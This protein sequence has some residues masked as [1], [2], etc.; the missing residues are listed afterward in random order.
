MYIYI[1]LFMFIPSYFFVHV[2][3]ARFGDRLVNPEVPA[4]GESGTSRERGF[5]DGA[6]ESA[7]WSR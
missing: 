7:T 5:A 4:V 2:L 3:L 1:T 6:T